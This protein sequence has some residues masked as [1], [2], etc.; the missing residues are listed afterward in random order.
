MTANPLSQAARVHMLLR[1]VL[2]FLLLSFAGIV[3]AQD[4]AL[5][6]P[7]VQRIEPVLADGWLNIDADV[8]LPV[9]DDL[10]HFA[11]KGVALYFTADIEIVKPRWWWFD[12]EVVKTQQTWRVIYNALTRQW[13]IGTGDLSLPE[14]SLDDALSLVRNIRGWA[15][16][17]LSELDAGEDY[18]GTLR[19]RLDT[20]LLARPFR[21]DALNSS[22]WSLSTPWQDFSFSISD[23]ELPR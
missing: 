16:V 17:P 7:Q 9:S 21:V 22:A 11:E 13:R 18:V 12:S 10:R 14:A 19:V 1:R 20:S 8:Y 23:A 3:H 6:N 15:V 5:V 2:F 4:T